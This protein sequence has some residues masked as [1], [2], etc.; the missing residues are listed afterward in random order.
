MILQVERCGLRGLLRYE[1]AGV[2]CD[3]PSPATP[4]SAAERWERAWRRK[5]RPT[6]VDA[7][8]D[9]AAA[10]TVIQCFQVPAAWLTF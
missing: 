1:Q 6:C 5:T 3:T 9:A 7:D 10:S 4:S 8:K 2:M